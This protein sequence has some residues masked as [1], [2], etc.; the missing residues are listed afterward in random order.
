MRFRPV[1]IVDPLLALA[2]VF[3]R[4][5]LV[6]FLIFMLLVMFVV[7]PMGI[8]LGNE[9]VAHSAVPTMAIPDTWRASLTQ[10]AIRAA[11]TPAPR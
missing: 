5:L 4:P 1:I 3:W 9:A 7:L 6:G 11:Q 8:S 10:G 2:I